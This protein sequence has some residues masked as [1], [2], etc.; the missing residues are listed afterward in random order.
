MWLTVGIVVAA[1]LLLLVAGVPWFFNWLSPRT[2]G[3]LRARAYRP[4]HSAGRFS[5]NAFTPSWMSSVVKAM[6]S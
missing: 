3:R 4:F 5:K 2:D 1:V 6:V